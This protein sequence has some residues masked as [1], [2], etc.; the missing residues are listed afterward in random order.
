M[1]EKR[2]VIFRYKGER[3]YI[4]GSDLFNE[5]LRE[6]ESS[7]IT[8]ITFTVHDFI[9]GRTCEI[10]STDFKKDVSKVEGIKSRCQMD[11]NGKTRWLVLRELDLPTGTNDDRYEYDEG[12]ITSGCE[13][14]EHT[15][16]LM[17]KSP[18]TFIETVVAM[19]KYLLEH[20]FPDA[21]GK[22]VFTRIDLDQFCGDNSGLSLNFKHNMNFRLLKSDIMLDGE[23]VG[24][25]GFSLVKS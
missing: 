22:W 12:R 17:D 10:I 4:H 24:A 2:D 3:N 1:I 7:Y 9:Q 6:S 18:L 11:V 8:N 23:K 5:L 20:L 14:S 19:N 21:E 25:L 13:I 16:I 15:I